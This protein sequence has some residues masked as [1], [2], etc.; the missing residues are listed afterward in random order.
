MLNEQKSTRPTNLELKATEVP[1]TGSQCGE[2][3]FTWTI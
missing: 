1:K 2:E 3:I